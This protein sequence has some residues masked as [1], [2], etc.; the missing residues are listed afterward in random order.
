L[1]I[2]PT[3]AWSEL[4]STYPLRMNTI[5]RISTSSTASV[6]KN[7]SSRRPRSKIVANMRSSISRGVF[8]PAGTFRLIFVFVDS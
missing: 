8:R 7:Q 5:D 3:I 1:A 6:V 4:K 2:N